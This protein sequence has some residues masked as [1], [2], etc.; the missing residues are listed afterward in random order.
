MRTH[1]NLGLCGRHVTSVLVYNLRK[2]VSTTALQDDITQFSPEKVYEMTRKNKS[3]QKERFSG[4]FMEV[5]SPFLAVIKE[6][7]WVDAPK[8]Y[9][10]QRGSFDEM[11]LFL[12]VVVVSLTGI[13]EVSRTKFFRGH[14]LWL[15]D[16]NALKLDEESLF[17]LRNADLTGEYNKF[18]DYLCE[19][20]A[21]STRCGVYNVTEENYAKAALYLYRLT[22]KVA[23]HN[24]YYAGPS[25]EYLV[26]L[27]MLF[28]RAGKYAPLL[29]KVGQQHAE[30]MEALGE[31]KRWGSTTEARKSVENAVADYIRRHEDAQAEATN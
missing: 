19:F 25:P 6:L 3:E 26:V 24:R 27:A 13:P 1:V 21:D 14:K 18:L 30:F 12:V 8:L 17:L 23:K 22:C 5:V 20:L 4:Y 9:T 28:E 15:F 7:H 10:L 29:D 11:I 16:E 31:S 2:A